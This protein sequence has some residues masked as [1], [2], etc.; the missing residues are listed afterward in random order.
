MKKKYIYLLLSAFVACNIACSSSDDDE[1]VVPPPPTPEQGEGEKPEPPTP[2]VEDGDDI[3]AYDYDIV[4]WNGEKADDAANDKPSY[5]VDL[6]YEANAFS[7]IVNV[8]FDGSKATVTTTNSKI[9]YNVTGGYVTIDLL[10]NLVKNTEIIVSGKSNDGGL[11][12]YGK[13]KFKLTMNGVELASR[14]GPAI[15]NQNKK[16]LFVHLNEGTTNILKDSTAY[17]D[18][19]HYVSTTAAEED[20]KGCFFSEGNMVFSGTGVLQVAARY[21]HGIATDSWFYTRPGVTIAITEAAKNAIH[22]KG[23]IDDNMGVKIAGGL[24]HATISS[25]AGKAIKTDHNVE[26]SGG[27][28]VLCTSGNAE[29]DSEEKDLS[30]AAGINSEGGVTISGGNVTI[31]SKG[32]AGKGINVT[33]DLTISGGEVF[34]ATTGNRYE[35]SSELTSSPKA[36]K[37]DGNINI[38]N[39]SLTIA[40]TGK[41]D[42]AEGLECKK[43]LTISGGD[44]NVYAYDDAISATEIFN[45]TNGT[46][47]TYSSANDGIDVN[48]TLTISGGQVTA[49]GGKSPEGGIDVDTKGKFVIDGGN[50]IALGGMMEQNPDAA[51]KQN[52]IVYGGFSFAK[53]DII[54]V[55]DAANKKVVNIEAPR[56]LAAATMCFSTPD[57]AAGTA[58]TIKLNNTDV[59]TFTPSGKVTLLGK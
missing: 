3:P 5:D 54:T 58:Y 30:S 23:D 51:G 25:P 4:Q 44:I 57:I 40:A 52:A 26:I 34:V 11:K 8:N 45:I 56:S 12:I 22:V 42:G 10:T 29:Y 16:A 14:R 2:P 17:V 59:T 24:I 55:V 31:K 41:C 36:V 32:D 43:E 7:N 21:R 53:K 48:G 49:I 38:S 39:G 1:E 20:R 19:A 18:D 33:T 28:V 47:Y 6:Y 37:A 9:K 27:K 15:N 50:V 35:Y 46:V 13:N